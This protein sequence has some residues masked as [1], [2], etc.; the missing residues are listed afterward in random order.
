MLDGWI[1]D[2]LEAAIAVNEALGRSRLNP[3]DVIPTNNVLFA[4]MT[5]YAWRDEFSGAVL[6]IADSDIQYAHIFLPAAHDP[7][8]ESLRI[9]HEIVID[10]LKWKFE[11]PEYWE[12]EDEPE[13]WPAPEQPQ[14]IDHHE[15]L[16]CDRT[17]AIID[18]LRAKNSYYEKLLETDPERQIL[19]L[20]ELDTVI[21]SSHRDLEYHALDEMTNMS[22]FS[23][24]NV[25]GVFAHRYVAQES[26]DYVVGRNWLGPVGLLC[27]NKTGSDP[28]KY[29]LSFV[30]VS[31]SY[32]G[33]GISK[34]LMRE[35]FRFAIEEGRF[36]VRTTPSEMGRALSYDRLTRLA[37]DEFPEV[38]FVPSHMSQFLRTFESHDELHAW[39]YPAK[40]KAIKKLMEKVEEVAECAKQEGSQFFSYDSLSPKVIHDYAQEIIRN[41]SA[42][43]SVTKA[44]PKI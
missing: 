32:R 12:D 2:V 19:N 21:Y 29:V 27:L 26:S 22:A 31:P 33:K 43:E 34:Q 9:R 10:P 3:D 1:E 11:Y 44:Y 5:S 35:A 25:R 36:I 7:Y 18:R 17:N 14:F 40:C 41:Q 15:V 20:K 6:R 38:P 4:L 37:V 13:V 28:S 42:P 8:S 39:T 16:V 23:G 30:S 24:G